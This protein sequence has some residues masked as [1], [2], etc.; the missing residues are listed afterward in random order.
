MSL[1]AN[2]DNFYHKIYFESCNEFEEVRELCLSEDNWLHN[3]YTVENLII[4][5]HH[6]YSVIYS[7]DTDEPVGMA[8]VFNDGRY[9]KN[10]ARQLHREYLFPKYRQKTRTEL[11]LVAK[12]YNSNAE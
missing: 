10:V 9:P 3:L 11:T 6:G 7:K 12:L 2:P 5:N 8:G 4:D 1:I